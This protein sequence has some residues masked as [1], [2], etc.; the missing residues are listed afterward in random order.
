MDDGMKSL[1]IAAVFLAA[2]TLCAQTP[3]MAKAAEALQT[4]MNAATNQSLPGVAAPLQ[5]KELIAL[6]PAEICGQRRTSAKGEKSGAMGINVAQAS[7]SYGG[8]DAPG[9]DVKIIDLAA[10]GPLGALT[11]L[12]LVATE[13]E[14]E[15]DDG[16]ERTVQYGDHKG[17]EKYS[18]ASKS[19]SVTVIVN[20]RFTVEVEGRDIEAG[21]LKTAIEALD[22]NALNDLS[23]KTQ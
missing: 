10:M 17:V 13:F 22:L 12:G 20:N 8:N 19:G 14:S 2:S 11:G 16:Y 23:R 15:S 4:L 1:S 5:P 9:F 6:L 21:Q 18:T 7:G 3:D